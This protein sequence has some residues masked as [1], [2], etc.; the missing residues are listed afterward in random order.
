MSGAFKVIPGLLKRAGMTMGDIDFFELNEAFAAV[1]AAAFHD[2]PELDVG[3]PTNGEAGLALVT[4]LVV[5]A[6]ARLLI[7]SNSR[8][9]VTRLLV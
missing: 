3:K 9:V 6:P 8:A 7:W 2:L 4:R 5:Q 1:V